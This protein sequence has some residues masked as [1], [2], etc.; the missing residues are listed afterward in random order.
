MKKQWAAVLLVLLATMTGCATAATEA[1]GTLTEAQAQQIALD[2][3]DISADQTTRMH[4][5]YEVDGGVPQFDIEFRQG[6]WEYE[7]EIHAESGQILSFDQEHWY[8]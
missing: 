6:D 1:T 3:L 7:F 8:D 5:T 2:Y 4:T